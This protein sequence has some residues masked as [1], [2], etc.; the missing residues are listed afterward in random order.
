[1]CKKWFSEHPE[2][3]VLATP[4]NSPD[5]NP[6]ENVWAESTR[7]W[8]TVFPRN[9][10]TLEASIVQ[11]WEKLRERPEYFKNL[12]ESMPRRLNAVIDNNGGPT[13]Y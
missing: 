3:D 2:L 8:K 12:Y 6:I 9:K 11:S 4:A 7:N 10:T 1:M 13:K 5:L